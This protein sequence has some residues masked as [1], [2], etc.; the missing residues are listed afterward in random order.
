[1]SGCVEGEKTR[2]STDTVSD[3]K[4]LTAVTADLGGVCT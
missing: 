4:A 1:M 3:S 2:Y